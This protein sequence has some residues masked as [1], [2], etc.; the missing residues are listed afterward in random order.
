MPSGMV[1]LLTPKA[2][3]SEISHNS[4]DSNRFPE[5]ESNLRTGRD[6]LQ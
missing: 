5:R 2:V 1:L 3:S 4:N 6:D